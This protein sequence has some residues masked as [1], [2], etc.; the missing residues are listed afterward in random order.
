MTK[1]WHRDSQKHALASKGIVTKYQYSATGKPMLKV[2][3]PS[4]TTEQIK[5]I[6]NLADGKEWIAELKELKS[7][8]IIDDIQISDNLDESFLNWN[9]GDEINDIGYI[10]YHPKELIP[11]FSAQDFVL[12]LT[13]HD[14]RVNKDKYP[15]TLMGLVYPDGD[16]LVIRV[17][18]I[19]ADK[20]TIKQFENKPIVESDMK[21]IIDKMCNN[22]ELIKMKEVVI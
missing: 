11:E 17:Y 1:G 4:F 22:K 13:I 15:Y 5:T 8:I 16:K 6:T 12:A 2:G 19:K 7:E 18:G 9:S 21:E 10:H 20:N 3:L 14:M